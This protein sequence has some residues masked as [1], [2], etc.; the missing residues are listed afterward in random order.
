[1]VDNEELAQLF[2]V[3]DSEIHG[4]GLYA[5]IIIEEGMYLG[6]YDGP[7]VEDD[8]MHVLWVEDEAEGKWTG[9]DGKNLLRY[10]NHSSKPIA[11]FDGF[12]LY[13]ISEIEPDTEITIDYGEEP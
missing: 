11:E 13:A 5:R 7:V 8:D 9:R 12:D 1:M 2:Y 3:Q 10:I 6:T 4:Q